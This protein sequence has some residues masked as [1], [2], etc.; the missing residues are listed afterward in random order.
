MET[1]LHRRI[2]LPESGSTKIFEGELATL[3]FDENGILCALAKSVPRTLEKQK[4]NYT[5]IRQITGNKK[6][7]L[8]SDTTSS[9]PQDKETRDYMAR[10]LP[11]VF[12]AMAVISESVTG[13]FITN[14]FL[15]LKRQP[16]PIKI[17]SDEKKAKEWLKQY[18]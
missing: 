13:I 15:T 12:K 1:L 17:F 2:K 8:L 4:E 9:R 7:C 6:V 18:L 5:F 14:V 10:E 16:I 3:W 11:N